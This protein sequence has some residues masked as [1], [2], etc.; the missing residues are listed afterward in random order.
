MDILAYFIPEN[1]TPLE[2]DRVEHTWLGSKNLNGDYIFILT[3]TTY[4]EHHP[5][6]YYKW[7]INDLGETVYVKPHT[8]FLMTKENFERYCIKDKR[9]SSNSKSEKKHYI[10]FN[11]WDNKHLNDL[12]PEMLRQWFITAQSKAT[13]HEPIKQETPERTKTWVFALILSLSILLAV[14][15]ALGVW[16]A[17][18]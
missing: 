3:T 17:V 12:D 4:N 10:R 11:G 14:A 7:F 15:I 2:S 9:L 1:L 8:Y 5:E 18:N 6:Q 13:F 16:F